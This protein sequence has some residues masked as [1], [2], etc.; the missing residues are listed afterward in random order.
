MT[1]LC[2]ADSN[3]IVGSIIGDTSPGFDRLKVVKKKPFSVARPVM[4]A[5][6]SYPM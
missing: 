5:D 3:M 1:R 2:E 6:C 4:G